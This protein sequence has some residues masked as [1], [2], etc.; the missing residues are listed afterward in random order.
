MILRR[1]RS[2]RIRRAGTAHLQAGRWAQAEELLSKAVELDPDD[3]W[4]AN[5][6]ATAL[7]KLGRFT[8][9][10]EVAC[11]ATEHRG[12]LPE[13]HESAGLALLSL[14]RWEEAAAAYGRA[15]AC[16]PDRPEAYQRW[17]IALS[18]LGRW[19]EARVAWERAVE[20]DPTDDT[21]REQ[22][23]LAHA[24][25]DR[26]QAAWSAERAVVA[27]G[28]TEAAREPLP[29]GGLFSFRG[30][31]QRLLRAAGTAHLRAGRWAA[32]A[33]RLE[34][35]GALDPGDV[36]CANNLATAL[37][38][39]G[40]CEEALEVARAAASL[41]PDLAEPH[42]SVG[43]ALL[44]LRRWEEAARA[45]GRAIE[46]ADD[47]HDSHQR[48]GIA[49]SQLGRWEEAR[50]AWERAVEIAPDDHTSR[51]QLHLARG[52]VDTWQ[53]EKSTPPPA[54]PRADV[55][56]CV[57]SAPMGGPQD[58][59]MAESRWEEALA[60]CHEA[61]AAR[62]EASGAHEQL[63]VA[64]MKLERWDE[65][66][67][68]ARR[69]TEC[70]RDHG[71]LHLRLGILLARCE[72]WEE[73]AEACRQAVAL[74]P[75]AV[76]AHRHL[77]QAAYHLGFWEEV[78]AACAATLEL[79]PN[80]PDA[81]PLLRAARIRRRNQ[82]AGR[83]PT[84]SAPPPGS[85]RKALAARRERFWSV[86][87]LGRDPL[88]VES[89]LQGMVC[90]ADGSPP[91]DAE[92]AVRPARLLFVLDNDYGELTTLMY[93]L[94]GQE[95]VGS[96][97]LLL[98][99]RLFANNA[100]ALPGRTHRYDTLAD[101]MDRV[102]REQPEVVFL[103]S[104]YL[105]TIHELLT[106][107]ELEELVGFLRAR[108]CRIVTTDPFLG[109]L[110]QGDVRSLVV[111]DISDAAVDLYEAVKDRQ[112]ERLRA[113]LT[114]CEEILRGA[115]HLY[116]TFCDLA[117]EETRT[118]DARNVSFFNSRLLRPD[119]D[120]DPERRPHWLFIL[121]QA[122][123]E[124]QVLVEGLAFIDLV[125]D[126]IVDAL[127]ARRHPILIGPR[128][129]IDA[130][131]DRLPT[132]EGVDLLHYCPFRQLVALSL[133]AEYA[134]YW[135]VL[136][137]SILIRLFNG[138]PIVVFDKGHLIR[139][140]TAVHERVVK[141]YYQGWEMPFTDQ[142]T[143]MTLESVAGSCRSF[144]EEAERLQRRFARAPSPADMI[145]DLVGRASEERPC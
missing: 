1:L 127:A 49:C 13:P 7:I 73:A 115:H 118:T 145:D 29:G 125:A 43:L 47:R 119:A 97:T 60:A 79:A 30:M 46:C 2:R 83:S 55:P 69:A 136:S 22:L 31:R 11:A 101:I 87:N 112:E 109:V 34:R 15:V 74:T 21:S 51:E 92:P 141:W 20:L 75:R 76:D 71:G 27:E 68:V 72:C 126:R 144:G 45:Y 133:S 82:G 23:E 37:I 35:A 120:D 41:R 61:I 26:L 134:F 142:K 102:E 93:L 89:W 105:M 135:N 123:Y 81:T 9:A 130:L 132:A 5:N 103:C 124:A 50:A 96:T 32:A 17:G 77:A 110:S 63:G 91:P 107:E 113:H 56:V 39:L 18:Q 128:E 86:A 14:R 48:L 12:D 40:R 121:S 116:P 84:A 24:Q 53:R 140:I 19:D 90:G 6:R 95:L 65:A 78:E 66:L 52:Q 137:H 54:S 138:Q 106:L 99:E 38:K 88:R 44:T 57:P 143:A 25:L 16:A 94:L 131:G 4:S 85:V 139:N 98:P 114:R 62:P 117:A 108:R 42:E 36:W 122:D 64:L 104:A 100:A 80:D 59:L 58:D 129:L 111:F 3:V 67:I 8:D 70:C 33:A 10:L 28:P